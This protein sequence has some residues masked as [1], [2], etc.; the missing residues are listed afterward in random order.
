MGERI[1]SVLLLCSGGIDST[2]CIHYYV[3]QGYL[4]KPIFIDYGQEALKLEYL[5]A[6]KITSYYKLNLVK[7]KI[8][9]NQRYSS[10]ETIGRNALLL[11]SA[12]M[13]NPG[14]K[15]IVSIGI[16]SG[17]PY[18]DCSELFAKDISKIINSYSDGQIVLD[19]PFL[20]WD[21]K[22][23]YRYCINNDVPISLTYSCELGGKV[24]CGKCLS[25]LDRRLLDV[26]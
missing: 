13:A 6:K 3:N 24:P 16:H 15:G 10:G 7:I 21:K 14:Y 5:S 4:I 2:A 20:K 26:S 22:S 23:I 12:I 11:L 1:K 18:Y 25:C 19:I 17:V 8:N 9:F